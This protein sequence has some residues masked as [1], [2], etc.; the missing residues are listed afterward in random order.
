[1][2]FEF[3][4]KGD[5][6]VPLSAPPP[7]EQE[8][9]GKCGG[10]RCRRVLEL[11]AN[12]VCRRFHSRLSTERSSYRYRPTR[13]CRRVLYRSAPTCR[14]SRFL[15]AVINDD[16]SK[17][18]KYRHTSFIAVYSLL[19]N[20]VLLALALLAKATNTSFFRSYSN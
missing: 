2:R 17:L 18:A 7:T 5:A 15:Q 19:R 16:R 14:P 13:Q 4:G 8:V 11:K 6:A 1:M 9:G 12:D 3:F 20:G 10:E